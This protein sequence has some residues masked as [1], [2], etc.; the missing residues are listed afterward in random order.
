MKLDYMNMIIGRGHIYT[1]RLRHVC[2]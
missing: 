1:H 2:I